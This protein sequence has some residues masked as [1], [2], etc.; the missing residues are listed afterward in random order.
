MPPKQVVKC[1]NCKGLMLSGIE[2]KTKTC[3]Y[4]GAK[5]TLKNAQKIAKADNAIEASEILKQLKAKAGFKPKK[6]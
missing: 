5:V 1:I 4:C 2:Q 6:P 3:P